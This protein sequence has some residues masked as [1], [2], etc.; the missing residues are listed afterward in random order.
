MFYIIATFEKR[1]YISIYTNSINN[2]VNNRYEND[3]DKRKNI[4]RGRKVGVVDIL[5]NHEKNNNIDSVYFQE[6]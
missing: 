3:I 1:T 6:A 2:I 4:F 5:Q